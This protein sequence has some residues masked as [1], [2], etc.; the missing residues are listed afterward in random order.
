[1]KI[2]STIVL[3]VLKVLTWIGFIG[4]CIKA[5]SIIFSF[6]ASLSYN[7]TAAKNLYLELNLWQLK[8]FN[9]TDY[10]ILVL[11]IIFVIILQAAMFFVLLQ[12]FKKINLV[13]PFHE[14]IGKLILRIS[15]ISLIIG[16]LSKLTIGLT[17]KYIK[18]GMDFP[19]LYEHV[20]QGNAFV[21]FAGILFFISILYKRG[22]ELQNEND[23]T[24]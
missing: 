13:S 17:S 20:G 18:L 23:L 22:I 11:S 21:F 12:I 24:I 10:V 6:F 8:E 7:P 1:M 9:N 3:K 14:K 16:L 4:L 15:A 2:N 19:H 5:G